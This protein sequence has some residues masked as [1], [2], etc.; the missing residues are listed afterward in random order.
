MKSAIKYVSEDRTALITLLK[1]KYISSKMIKKV[2][3]QCESTKNNGTGYYHTISVLKQ[4]RK[5]LD[6]YIL[7]E[8]G[9]PLSFRGFQ[10]KRVSKYLKDSSESV[11]VL[12]SVDGLLHEFVSAGYPFSIP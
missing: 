9:E 1:N 12:A 11:E 10:R 7:T 5:K 8:R 4:L 6:E 2:R 3:A